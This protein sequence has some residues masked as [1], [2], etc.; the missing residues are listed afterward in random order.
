[1]LPS[2]ELMEE[3]TAPTNQVI[4]R[5][6]PLATLF[7][8]DFGRFPIRARS[9]NQYIML[10]YHD[11]TNVILVQPFALKTDNHRIPAINAIMKRFKARGI[12]VDSQVMDN[13]AS[14]AYLNNIAEVWKCTYQ[15]V[16]PDMHRRNK[17]ERAIRT[18]KAHFLAI[19]A[20]VDPAFPMN[21]WDLLLPQAEI[22]VNLLRQ[23]L[24][25][26]HI[27]AWEHFNGPFNF[28][29]TPMG[30]PGCKVIAHAKGSTRKSWDF[31][32][33]ASFYFYV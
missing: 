20:S 30:P 18:F 5:V 28:D 17:A 31:R 4:F 8:D 16:P 23:S 15:K 22:T 25:H 14:E 7:T 3:M 11:A 27:S 10:A 19:L 6:V 32:G 29:A 1:M 12:T 9:G 24:L 13:E 33:H 21:R 26:P 2:D